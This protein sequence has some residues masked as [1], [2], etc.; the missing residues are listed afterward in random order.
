MIFPAFGEDNYCLI[1]LDIVEAHVRSW[2]HALFEIE[3]SRVNESL[4][5]IIGF[6]N[7]VT[8][9]CTRKFEFT[10]KGVSGESIERSFGME[11]LH[12]IQESYVRMREAD[13]RKERTDCVSLNLAQNGAIINLALGLRAGAR[14]RD[15]LYPKL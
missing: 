4:E 3:V 11:I 14:I 5:Y 15:Q 13:R 9:A 6:G 7:G 8:I 10:L 1:S 12:A 2:A